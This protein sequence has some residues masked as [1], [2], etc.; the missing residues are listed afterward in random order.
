[1]KK[2]ALFSLVVVAAFAAGVFAQSPVAYTMRGMG[3]VST[4]AAPVVNVPQLCVG[5]DDI[6]ASWGGAYVSLKPVGGPGG[7]VKS[8]SGILPDALGNV[9]LT[10][11]TKVAAPSFNFSGTG[12]L[13]I[14]PPTATTTIP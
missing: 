8:V 5:T 14:N 7:T 1:M 2:I 11:T 3:P 13:T 6:V 9:P 4:C 10:A 12:A